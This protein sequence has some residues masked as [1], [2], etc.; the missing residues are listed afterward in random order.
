MSGYN[1]KKL[2]PL[3]DI[4]DII[5]LYFMV[6][7]IMRVNEPAKIK[8]SRLNHQPMRYICLAVCVYLLSSPTSFCTKT[9]PLNFRFTQQN[10]RDAEKNGV[11]F[12]KIN[13][14]SWIWV[15]CISI[16]FSLLNYHT[17]T[18]Q[19]QWRKEIATQ[20]CTHTHTHIYMHDTHI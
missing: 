5:L 9:F 16:T 2:G 19:L 18:T 7:K 10:S 6:K 12:F 4:S 17:Y 11:N 20:T 1:D 3:F 15:Q 8:N 14:G 13:F